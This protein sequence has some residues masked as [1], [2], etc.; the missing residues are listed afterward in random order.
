MTRAY[1]ETRQYP[2][3]MKCEDKGC[4]HIMRYHNQLGCTLRN[5]NCTV[6]N[7]TLKSIQKNPYFRGIAMEMAAC[8][9]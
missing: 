4:R 5:C 6:K 7:R 8:S 3:G 2:P 1:G 9:R